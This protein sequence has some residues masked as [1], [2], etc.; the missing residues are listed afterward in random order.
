MHLAERQHHRWL[1]PAGDPRGRWYNCSTDER[2]NAETAVGVSDERAETT[3][4]SEKV[5]LK[6]SV[7]LS[8][9]VQGSV[10]FNAFSKQAETFSTTVTATN[11]VAVAPGWEGYTTT[12]VLSADV[13]GSTYITEGINKLIEVKDIDLSFPGYQDAHDRSSPQVIYNGNSA[14]MTA[15][16]IASRCN[17]VSDSPTG[18]LGA[19]PPAR[20]KVA[21]GSFKLTLCP[22]PAAGRSRPL[23]AAC[24][25]RTVAG[26]PPLASDATAT[27]IAGGRTYA[28]GTDVAG[29]IRLTVRRAIRR[30]KYTLWLRAQA[31]R[32][33]KKVTYRRTTVVPITIR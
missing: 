21:T 22:Q 26:P 23:D 32:G 18:V 1:R 19:P 30:G 9:L 20:R 13:I 15:A 8:D 5:S 24:K 4:V 12:Q 10:E 28:A 17:A 25:A 7:G 29:R 11:A 2:D 16:E 3:S 31:G 6:I 14:P 33:A 27:L